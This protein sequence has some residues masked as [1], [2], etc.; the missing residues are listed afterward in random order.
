MKKPHPF[1]I[2]GLY[3][4]TPDD[5]DTER[6]CRK[7]ETALQGGVSLVQYRNKAANAMLRLRQA[8]AL[9]AICRSYKVSLVINDHLDLCAQIDA[10]GL[11]LGMTDCDLSA[12]R[13]LL[14]ADKIIGASCYNQP[15]LAIKAEQ[16]GASYVAFGACFSSETKPNAL[17]APLSLFT[18]AKQKIAIPLVAIGGITLEN[19]PS[20]LQAGADAI[21]VVGALF[22]ANDII[23]TSQQFMHLSK[24]TFI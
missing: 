1:N 5:L 19:A 18:E 9:L 10:D 14:G 16:A 12:A 23:E 20:V 2:S 21:A 22:N 3:A 17:H 7:V 13:R 8:S 24:T 6:L 11:H 15:E 4:I